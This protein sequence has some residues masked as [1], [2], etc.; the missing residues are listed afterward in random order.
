MAPGGTVSPA[1]PGKSLPGVAEAPTTGQSF[2]EEVEP[3]DTSATAT[4]TGGTD[5]VLRGYV[6]G[7]GDIDYWSFTAAAGDR[8]YAATQTSFSAS[9]STDSVLTLLGT[10]GSTTLEED[11]NDG[12]FG[13]SSSTIAGATIPSAGT[14]FLR[15]RHFSAT[16]QLR[17][18]HLHLKVQSGSPTAEVEP[19][20]TPATATLLPVSGWV[21][22]AIA[23][24]TDV[25][26]FFSLALNAGD[27]VFLSLDLDPERDTTTWNGRV[28]FGVFNGFILVANDASVTSPNSE[29]FFMT[30]KDAGTYYVYVDPATAG[31]GGATFTYNLSVGVRPAGAACTTTT[32]TDV[33]K[34]IPDGPGS[35][36]STVTVPPGTR[37]GSMAVL[38]DLTHANMPDLDITLTSPDGNIVGLLSDIGASTPTA[39]NLRLDDDAGLPIGLFTVVSGMVNQPELSY[40]LGWFNGMDAAGVWTLTIYDDTAVNGGTLNSW[41]LVVCPEA[42]PA[43]CTGGTPTTLFTSDFEASDGGFTHSGTADEWERGLP[44]FAP[45]TTCHSG[46]NCWK[47]DLDSTY[48]ASSTQELV[49]PPIV[50]S[51][52][53][54]VPIRVS[55][56]QKFQM[57]SASFDHLWVEVRPAG[58]PTVG[59]KLYEWHDATMTTFAGATTVDESAGWAVL[60]ADI[61]EYA[62]QSVEIRFHVDTDS[63]ANYAGVAIDDVT[64]SSCGPVPV[65]LTGFS[66]E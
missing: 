12:S 45:I 54:T 14:Y 63:S 56:A 1:R 66:V 38:L 61:S 3:N 7:N 25:A 29:A 10:D 60:S 19:N 41:G 46:T 39:M 5:T 52:P 17:P 40:R 36:T 30:V 51:G 32:S 33:P 21:S 23:D 22:G 2:V 9:G 16:T 64:V 4:A 20:D 48:N 31:T 37:I 26:D 65:E 53:V 34:T 42:T 27:T 50:L 28:G 59:R 18:Y 35:V 55:W 24:T 62:G 8:V 43:P 15:V 11:D 58:S 44:S 57:E 47:T 13:T 49:S 6:Y